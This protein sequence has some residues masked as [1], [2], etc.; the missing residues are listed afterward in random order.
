MTDFEQIGAAGYRYLEEIVTADVAFE[1][2][3]MTLEELFRVSADAVLNV[4]IE[5]IE[6]VPVSYTHLTLPTILRV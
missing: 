4:M 6:T 5:D 3:G 2:W 1:A